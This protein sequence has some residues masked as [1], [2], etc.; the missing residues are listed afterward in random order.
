LRTI[1]II[2]I[3]LAVGGVILTLVGRSAWA[4]ESAPSPPLVTIAY[5]ANEKIFFAIPV[6]TV[7]FDLSKQA[8]QAGLQL[9]DLKIELDG[10]P[11]PAGGIGRWHLY[12]GHNYGIFSRSVTWAATEGGHRVAFRAT[13]ATGREWETTT[14]YIIETSHPS[15]TGLSGFL[16]F[17][18]NEA[19]FSRSARVGMTTGARDTVGRA[20]W[21]NLAPLQFNEKT[22]LIPVPIELGLNRRM[23]GRSSGRSNVSWKLEPRAQQGSRP[24][25]GFGQT[26]GNPFVVMG[27]HNNPRRVQGSLGLGA[28]RLPDAF[29]GFSYS[30][31]TYRLMLEGDSRRNFNYGISLTHPRGIRVTLANLQTNQPHRVWQLGL[32]LSRGL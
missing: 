29:F 20:A 1:L 8:R 14:D 28:H 24:G 11:V 32:S 7:I 3:Y 12:T 13:D 2:K 10:K 6:A 27:W 30:P 22:A 4:S 31:S 5:P 16:L 23:S 15:A 21:I 26:D 17:P 25:L 19:I 18:S 9:K